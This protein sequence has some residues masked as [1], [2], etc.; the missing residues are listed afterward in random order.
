M[1]VGII[2]PEFPPHI[3]G[4][5]TYSYEFTRELA[6]RGYAVTVFTIAHK[7]GE[8]RIPG[9]QV[10]PALKLSCHKDKQILQDHKMDVWHIM[11]A[12]YAWM[13]IESEHV[14]A[15][16]HGNDF[17]L[18]YVLVAR[19]NLFNFWRLRRIKQRLDG[20]EKFFGRL[21]TRRLMRL[22][23]PMV[24]HIITNSYYTERVLLEH[25]PACRGKTS[26]GMVGV[27]DDYL[28][29]DY[30]LKS[31]NKSPHLIT[32][33]R[34]SE[35]RKNVSCV[36]R[37]LAQLKDNYDFI[38]TVVGDGNLRKSLEKLSQ[39]V[40]LEKRVRFRGLLSKTEVKELLSRSDLF[41]LTSSIQHKN[42]EGFGIVYLEAN[43]CG[44]PVLA[45]R[46]AGAEEAVEEGVSGMFVEEPTENAIANAIERFLSGQVTF[47]S[48]S[49]RA[50]A[51]RFSWARVVN[52]ALNAYKE[53][54]KFTE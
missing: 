30:T 25:Y 9:V 13:A 43:A 5:E 24:H 54:M 26:V 39:K 6:D 20:I 1:R 34:L 49:C 16:V 51:C 18:P 41:I 31:H 3:G 8:M 33:C 7:D 19:P 17:L 44:T 47:E 21:L 29:T 53:V 28:N 38:Y 45:S 12:A 32:V 23:L 22:S 2:A 11:N 52:H 46:L 35:P 50:F 15:S 4:V 37:A 42:Y 14:V 27:S 10:I 40:G 48:E 36:L